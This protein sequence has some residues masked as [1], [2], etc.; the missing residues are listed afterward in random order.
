MRICR[1]QTSFKEAPRANYNQLL[2]HVFL[3]LFPRCGYYTKNSIVRTLLLCVRG[4]KDVRHNGY[5]FSLSD[6]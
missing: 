3:D 5:W 2:Q 6:T 1:R 4:N